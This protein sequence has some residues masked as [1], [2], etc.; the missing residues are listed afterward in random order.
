MHL[1]SH[2]GHFPMGL[3][4]ARLSAL[5]QEHDDVPSLGSELS[6]KLF[7][8]PNIQV[9]YKAKSLEFFRSFVSVSASILYFSRLKICI[10]LLVHAC[11]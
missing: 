8:A 9:S 6:T 3:G 11:A 4:A 2:L 7:Y 5:V 10:F 1:V